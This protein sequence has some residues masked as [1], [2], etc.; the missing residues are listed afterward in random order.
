[1]TESTDKLFGD[2]I[3]EGDGIAE[4]IGEHGDRKTLWRSTSRYNEQAED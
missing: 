2:H 3:A 1:M 4:K